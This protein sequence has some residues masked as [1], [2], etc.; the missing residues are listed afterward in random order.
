[1]PVCFPGGVIDLFSW[2]FRSCCCEKTGPKYPLHG[3]SSL[4]ANMPT[5]GRLGLVENLGEY[6]SSCGYCSRQEET[7]LATGMWAH[8]LSVEAYQELLDRGWRRSG[9]WLYKPDS[10]RT[11]CPPYT[12]RL[13]VHKF[14]MTKVHR[15]VLRKM[16]AYLAGG[17]LHAQQQQQQQ[18]AARALDA[19]AETA[20]P[21]VGV[22]MPDSPS[23]KRRKMANGSVCVPIAGRSGERPASLQQEVK[24][25]IGAAV[26]S[27]LQQC[28]LSGRLPS[29]GYP[30][31]RVQEP[32]AKQRKSLAKGVFFTS[33]TP[34]AV[35][36]MACKA[37]KGT[38]YVTG[39]AV[40][41]MLAVALAARPDT[42][43]DQVTA[44]QFKRFLIDTPLTYV[45]AFKCPPGQSPPCG[46]G[47]FHQQYWID[48]RL[49]AVGVI[50]VLPNCLSSKYFFWDPEF[51][52]LA[53]G[54][55]SALKEIGWVT[56]AACCCPSLHYYY[57]GYY[58]HSCP[59][60][61][62]KADYEPS[63]LLCNQ[64]L[65]WVP[66]ERCRALLDENEDGRLVQFGQLAMLQAWPREV[67]QQL[68]RKLISWHR[69]VGKAAE[70]LVYL[71]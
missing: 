63:D 53:L 30:Q 66:Y 70:R 48:G 15:K 25:E 18:L 38:L 69:L 12:V 64:R 27:A 44:S 42:G 21:A 4:P 31:V 33:P 7:S 6:A 65:C 20:L 57:M 29:A 51:A 35:A 10:E 47:T 43:T 71:M 58:I 2:P 67:M 62:Y 5:S 19:A 3:E 39:E 36:A 32:T 16:D 17:L 40:A 55:F 34:L 56:Q 9:C 49:V 68:R 54:K 11:C 52:P 41:K 8:Q 37:A 59:K 45:P 26:Q 28:I 14:R 1:M 24:L 46:F 60:M 13:D 22:R 61:R 23:D 50:D